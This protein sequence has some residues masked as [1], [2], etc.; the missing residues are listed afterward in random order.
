M[1][2][3]ATMTRLFVEKENLESTIRFY[4]ELYAEKCQLRFVYEEKALELAQVKNILIIAGDAEARRPF[5]A[6]QLTLLVD[7]IKE[8]EQLLRQ[9][10]ATILEAPQQ[11]PTGWNM[12]VQYPDGVRVEY[13]GHK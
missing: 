2:V 13:V 9:L 6:T 10:G 8:T 5:E 11:V 4:E 1:T 7:S 3:L 12:L